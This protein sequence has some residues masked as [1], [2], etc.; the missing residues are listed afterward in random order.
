[1][2]QKAKYN[3]VAVYV[4]SALNYLCPKSS[5]SYS[6][7]SG[8]SQPVDAV[9]FISVYAEISE[10]L[11]VLHRMVDENYFIMDSCFKTV[12]HD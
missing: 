11:C 6:S 10:G 12:T 8:I 3:S 4:P 2:Q 1:M 9:G 5:Q 7:S